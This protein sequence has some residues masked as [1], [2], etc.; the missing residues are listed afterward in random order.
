VL[1]GADAKLFRMGLGCIGGNSI[2]VVAFN[3]H[4]S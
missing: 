4:Y 1:S 2:C 3:Y